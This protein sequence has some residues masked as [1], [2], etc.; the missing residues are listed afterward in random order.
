MGLEWDGAQW[1][2]HWHGHFIHAEI[3]QTGMGSF[4]LPCLVHFGGRLID[5]GDLID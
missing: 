1:S 2:E 3:P 5:N 4:A